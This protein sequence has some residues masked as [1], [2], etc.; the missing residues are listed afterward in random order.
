MSHFNHFLRQDILG[1]HDIK[2]FVDLFY[3]R[4]QTEPALNKIFSE[5]ANVQWD[6]HLETMYQFWNRILFGAGNF[7]GNP[8][9]THLELQSKIRATNIPGLTEANF[10]IWIEL[11]EQTIDELFCGPNAD[12]AKLAA[13]R[14]RDH[15]LSV[16]NRPPRKSELNFVPHNV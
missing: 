13:H 7:C 5:V 3:Q 12:S 11:F 1:I 9:K 14:M 6:V 10:A 16:L 8:L 4:V 2:R 15:L